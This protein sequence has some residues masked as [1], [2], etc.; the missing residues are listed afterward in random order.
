[1]PKYLNLRLI[2]SG[3]VSI[4]MVFSQSLSR[5]LLNKP[6]DYKLVVAR[7]VLPNRMPIF[8]FVDGAYT[9]NMSINGIVST[10]LSVTY[11]PQNADSNSRVVYQIQPFVEMVNATISQSFALLKAVSGGAIGA[12]VVPPFIRYDEVTKL[13]SLYAQQLYYDEVHYVDTPPTARVAP[14]QL[15][16]GTTL[17]RMFLG[18]PVYA[19]MQPNAPSYRFRIYTYPDASNVVTIGGQ[20]Y[21]KMTQQA[22]SFSQ[23][24]DFHSIILTSNLPIQNEFSLINTGSSA[25]SVVPI[26][27][28]FCPEELDVGDFNS[29]IVYNS[30]YPYRKIN[31]TSDSPFYDVSVSCY[32]SS[33]LGLLTPLI[34]PAGQSANIKLMFIHK[35]EDV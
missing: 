26:I 11:L 2:N 17:N 12:G 15:N 18:F 35:D 31:I 6:S 10:T 30:I 32:T 23:I 33:D 20:P 1:M 13:F 7:F 9:M 14:I 3:A 16:F 29:D 4:P 25:D 24:T 22:T 5:P 8:T 19:T 27:S 21:V 34:L 28:D